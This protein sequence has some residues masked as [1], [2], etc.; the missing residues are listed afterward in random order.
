MLRT[1][2]IL[3]AALVSTGCSA[4][5][6]SHGVDVNGLSTKDE[7]RRALGTPDP[8]SGSLCDEFHTHRKLA[9]NWKGE[10][11]LIPAVVTFG[12]SEVVY[13][14]REVYR[15]IEQRVAGHTIQVF[16]DGDGKVTYVLVNGNVPFL[17]RFHA[18]PD[19][20]GTPAP[21]P[22]DSR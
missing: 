6:A 10:Y 19:P 12:L 4:F 8:G 5:V 11:L 3:V 18:A 15:A 13:F 2:P 9:E 14:P 21:K 22:N 7:V 1:C 20:R 16:Y 17:S